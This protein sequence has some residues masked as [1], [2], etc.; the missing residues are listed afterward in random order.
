[1][2]KGEVEPH[3]LWKHL[4]NSQGRTFGKSINTFYDGG[5]VFGH[6]SEGYPVGLWKIIDEEKSILIEETIFIR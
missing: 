4:K 2:S 6:I 3:W 1:M 5:F